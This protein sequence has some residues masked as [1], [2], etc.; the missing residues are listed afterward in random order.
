VSTSR[1][2]LELRAAIDAARKAGETVRDLYERSAATTYTKSDGSPVT[3]ADL[4]ADRI[5]RE[6]ISGRFPTDAFLTE[7]GA[8]DASRLSEHRIWIVDPIDGTQQFVDRT[9]EFD[10]LIALVAGGYPVVSVMLQPTTGHYLAAE[11]GAG[12]WI[13]RSDDLVRLRFDPVEPNR[14]PRLQTSNWLNM[15]AAAPGLERA[16]DRLGSAAP[17]VSPYGIVARHFSPPD[18]RFDA[19]IGLPT[20]AG[21]TMAWEWDFAA[22]D[23]IVHEAGGAFT[24]VWGRRFRYNK[25]VPRNEG[26]VLMSVDP[27]THARILAALKPE[28]PGED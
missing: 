15:P 20:R 6:M 12:A 18:H 10:V 9:G 25:P 23:L 19:L 7:E 16:A 5:I 11:A 21:Q 17:E 22:A 3:D 8:D 4:A 14:A 13:G 1:Y 28:L 26:G 24:D 2:S 27:E